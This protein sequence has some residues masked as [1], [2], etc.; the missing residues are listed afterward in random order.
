[1][2]PADE[3]AFGGT[4]QASTVEFL[5]APTC[6]NRCVAYRTR[7][8]FPG[9]TYHVFNR[10][11]YRHWIFATRGALESF[12]NCF[13]E[14]V[15][16]FK[17]QIHAFGFMNNHFH[18]S[19]T[20]PEPN[21]SVGMQWLQSTYAVRFN[22]FRDERGHL[23]QGR[24]H[25]VL[26]QPGSDL[27]RVVN[28]IHLNPVEAGIVEVSGLPHS[29][30]TSLA[31]F[32]HGPRPPWLSCEP[33][34]T[35]LGLTDTASGWSKYLLYLEEVSK[36]PRSK[37]EE[38]ALTRGWAIGT[39]EWRASIIAKI[40]GQIIPRGRRE[41]ADACQLQWSRALEEEL[42]KCS[43]TKADLA[44]APKGAPWKIALAYALRNSTTATNNWIAREV[45][46]GA[47]SSVSQYMS[48]LRRRI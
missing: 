22:R 38:R 5:R 6:Y 18:F 25:S 16:R 27:V 43:K 26:V 41:T 30:L 14:T 37:E 21:L 11:N 1:M 40:T 46:M 10:G 9:A 34:L 36:I 17:W 20:T 8:E 3:R 35:T 12:R 24:Y 19:A 7:R 44:L 23:F 47:A 15:P 48:L 29:S 13:F 33:W 31:Q 32:I 2:F 45:H 4:P 28:Y 42:I 39:T